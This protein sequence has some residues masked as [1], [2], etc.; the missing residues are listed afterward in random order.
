VQLDALGVAGV[1]RE[2]QT[3]DRHVHEYD[4]REQNPA[5]RD[6]EDAAA[7]TGASPDA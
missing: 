1:E 3:Q 5:D 4:T 6:P 2:V 7:G